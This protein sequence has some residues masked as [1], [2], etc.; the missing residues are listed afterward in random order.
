MAARA[1]ER[2]R[3]LKKAG[4]KLP[5][6]WAMGEAARVACA[7]R[8]KCCGGVVVANARGPAP[9]SLFAPAGSLLFL[10]KK[11]L[12]FASSVAV[13]AMH[14]VRGDAVANFRHDQPILVLQDVPSVEIAAAPVLLFGEPAEFVALGIALIR[15]L[16]IVVRWA[17]ISTRYFPA[18][19]VIVVNAEGVPGYDNGWERC[20]ELPADGFAGTQNPG[21]QLVLRRPNAALRQILHVLFRLILN[22]G[23][24][25]GS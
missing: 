23:T 12:E 6:L 16:T 19:D 1:K 20:C 9:K 4:Q 8:M 13:L 14:V 25:D 22:E 15:L 2:S 5:G 3:C 7:Q 21:R 18:D 17:D 24:T 10:Q 11:C